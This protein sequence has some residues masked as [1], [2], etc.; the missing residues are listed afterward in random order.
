MDKGAHFYRCD[1]QVHTPRDRN[2][3]GGECLTD[4]QRKQYATS[5]IQACRTRGLQGIAITDHHDMA[6]VD[7][8]RTAALAETDNDA[9]SFQRKGRWWF[10]L[11]WSLPWEFHARRF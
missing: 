9:S 5:L 2:W 6:F 3:K 1:L 4:Q 7:Y 10:S 11:E 8:V